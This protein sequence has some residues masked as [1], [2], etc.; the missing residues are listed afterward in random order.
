MPRVDSLPVP[1]KQGQ[2]PPRTPCPGPPQHPVD[3]HPVITPPPTPTRHPV[4][5][6]RLQLF[7]LGIGQIMAIMHKQDL[8]HPRPKI[9][10]TR[11][12][13]KHATATAKA[14]T[15]YNDHKR[16]AVL[17]DMIQYTMGLNFVG[18][19]GFIGAAMRCLRILFALLMIGSTITGVT[20][21]GASAQGCSAAVDKISP[22]RS[23]DLRGANNW[24]G[25]WSG[26][27]NPYRD[28]T[29]GNP[30]SQADLDD[31]RRLGANYLQL[32]V[33]GL[34]AE[35][36]PY[37]LDVEAQVVIDN[38]VDLASKAHLY[39]AIAFRSG[40]G[41]NEQAVVRS[42]DIATYGP[43]VESFWTDSNAQEAWLD[44]LHYAAVRYGSSPAVIGIEP[45]VEPNSYARHGFK[46]PQDFYARYTD[47]LED[48]NQ[49]HA[50]ATV[51]IRTASDVPILLEGDGFGTVSYLP[52]LKTTGDSRT[53]Y[54]VHYYE[55]IVFT[56]QD[57]RR[58]LS[59][60]GLMPIGAGQVIVDKG[61]HERTLLPL[62]TF[63]HTK[64]VPVAVTEFGVHR[65]AP[66]AAAYLSDVL[67][68]F[69]DIGA[70]HALWEFVVS[71]QRPLFNDFDPEGGADA[72]RRTKAENA[73]QTTI[74]ENLQKNCVQLHGTA[75]PNPTN[76]SGPK[77]PW[78]SI[79]LGL[80]GTAATVAALLLAPDP[81][82]K[83]SNHRRSGRSP[84][85]Q[86][87]C[88]R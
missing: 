66:G 2:V 64:G 36:P 58:R 26:S 68:V 84:S 14:A 38:I 5:Q 55:P 69:E 77:Q 18:Q 4:R 30:I 6:Q 59:Y 67:N 88:V 51:A 15:D 80:L 43:I 20:T 83:K 34:Y 12:N 45:I 82:K 53:I 35:Q 33:A 7:P 70:A 65:Y 8:P 72:S 17:T 57:P 54:T 87:H 28:R 76:D 52:Y 31:L 16:R 73:V 11:P 71:T 22:W 37:G 75:V 10:Q 81:D 19:D 21:P 60:P 29:I 79:L 23:G 74:E 62:R 86:L 27:S 40:P 3:H 49:F 44:M 24:Q 9:R 78:I 61:F 41:R 47:T 39:V 32:S 42:T 63:K 85:P 48:V 25:R 1:V 56:H 13:A 50:R 46:S